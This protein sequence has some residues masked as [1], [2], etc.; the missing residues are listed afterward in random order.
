M[1]TGAKKL[2]S[3]S[4]LMSGLMMVFLFIAIAF[5]LKTEKE[6]VKLIKTTEEAKKQSR[7]AEELRKEAEKQKG[8]AEKQKGEAEKRGKQLAD[9]LEKG[10]LRT[11]AIGGILATYSK[12]QGGLYEKLEDQ[13]G[14]DLKNWNATLEKDSTI[15]FNKPEVLFE[16]GEA[17]LK[18]KFIS[19]LNDF[20]PR[21]VDILNKNEIRDE[22]DEIRVEG[23]TSSEWKG[24]KSRKERYLKNVQLSQKRALS[25]LE[26]SVSLIKDPIKDEWLSKKLRANGLSFAKPILDKNGLENADRSRRV[27]FRVLAKTQEKII[28]I[29]NEYKD[30]D[31]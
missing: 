2:G 5:M 31:N 11:D 7:V 28:Q 3:V 12:L 9:A 19:I 22:I 14:K 10:Q 25:V 21:Y 8:E 16:A 30:K 17:E 1:R 15:R 23:H 27:E 24:A 6:K 18:Q 4:D 13:F 20:F 29:I 26:Y